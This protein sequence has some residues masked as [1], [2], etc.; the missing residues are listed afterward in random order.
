MSRSILRYIKDKTDLHSGM[1]G[2]DDGRN[3]Q[4]R[5]GSRDQ[6]SIITPQMC[7]RPSE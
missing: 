7:K 5:A 3:E 1:G 6:V 2:F 4:P